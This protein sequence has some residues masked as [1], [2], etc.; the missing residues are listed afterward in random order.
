[1]ALSRI[2]SAFIIIAL[3]TATVKFL[4]QPGQQHI[5]SQLMTGK[6]TDTISARTV[7]SLSLPAA[8]HAQLQVQKLAIWEKDNVYRTGDN[9]YRAYR[10]QSANGV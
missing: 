4:V 5:F 9:S 7:D 10:I 1:M 6:N 2:W 3:L 8:V